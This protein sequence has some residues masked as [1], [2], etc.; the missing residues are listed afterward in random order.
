[1]PELHGIVP[2]SPDASEA[3]SVVSSDRRW[4]GAELA[5][6]RQEPMTAAEHA[7]ANGLQAEYARDVPRTC[8]CT[9]Q[10]HVRERR[11]ERIFT[12]PECPW[13]TQTGDQQ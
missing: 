11:Y 10:W 5:A 7:E 6:E 2:G 9:W 1:M 3:V 8:T 4:T 13:D 12:A